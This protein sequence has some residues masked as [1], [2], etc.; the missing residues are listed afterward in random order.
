VKGGGVHEK[1]IL[2]I[3]PKMTECES[4]LDLTNLEWYTV[5]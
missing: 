3:Y 1:I 2:K 4:G 5:A